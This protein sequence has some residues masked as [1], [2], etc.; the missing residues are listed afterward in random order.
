MESDSLA[1][2]NAV[3]ASV[4]AEHA[5]IVSADILPFKEP[6]NPSRWYVPAGGLVYCVANETVPDTVADSILLRRSG[7]FAKVTAFLEGSSVANEEQFV[8]VF[9]VAPDGTRVLGEQVLTHKESYSRISVQVSG[10][11]TIAASMAHEFQY[12]DLICA[13]IDKPR[14]GFRDSDVG[15]QTA[16][17]VKWRRREVEKVDWDKCPENVLLWNLVEGL[18][19][20]Q[21]THPFGPFSRPINYKYFGCWSDATWDKLYSYCTK[22]VTALDDQP[23]EVIKAIAFDRLVPIEIDFADNKLEPLAST[24]VA[25]GFLR[26]LSEVDQETLNDLIRQFKNKVESTDSPFKEATPVLFYASVWNILCLEKEDFHSTQFSPYN[27]PPPV[28][29]AASADTDSDD[30]YTGDESQQE[31]NLVT[32]RSDFELALFIEGTLRGPLA[33]NP[34]LNADDAR[35][36]EIINIVKVAADLVDHPNPEEMSKLEIQV[37][38]WAGRTTL[39]FARV[40]EVSCPPL[41][42]VAVCG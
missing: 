14:L 11:T 8:Y 41:L 25:F 17:I 9:G 38:K 1:Y 18:K 27:L 6:E 35:I 22:I 4:P 15:F 3:T 37:T 2:V 29:T 21:T 34:D 26:L 30:F 36:D 7:G 20:L 42:C 16:E 39:P 33:I 40:L 24:K 12:G 32:E 19:S 5:V 10:T 28:G 31:E 23:V 13:Q